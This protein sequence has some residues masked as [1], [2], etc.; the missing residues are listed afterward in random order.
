MEILLAGHP[1]PLIQLGSNDHSGT[2]KPAFPGSTLLGTSLDFKP[3]SRRMPFPK[4]STLLVYTDGLT[5]AMNSAG[6]AFSR[7]KVH[8]SFMQGD[9][10][11]Q[12]TLAVL[13]QNWRDHLSDQQPLDDVCVVAVRAS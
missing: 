6:K 8:S 4:G 9:R 1:A 3:F 12:E 7:R 10:D 2:T 5:E 11:P 13:L